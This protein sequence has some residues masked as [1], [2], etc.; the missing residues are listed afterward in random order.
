QQA[1][2]I[3]KNKS[4]PVLFQE[5]YLEQTP[6]DKQREVLL[7]SQK[8]KVIVCGRRSGKTQM[9]AGELIRGAITR[10]YKR[11][12]VIAP[13]YKQTLIVYNKILE[14]MHKGKRGNDILRV[15]Q[16][17]YP[18]IEL[19]GGGID[20]GSAD[21]PDSLRGEA[22][23]RVF[24]DES[25]FIKEGAMDAIKPLTFDTGAPIWETTTPW[26][27]GSV[28]ERWRRGL[29]GDSDYG[30]FHYNYK[31]NI[32]LADEGVKEIEKDIKEWGEDSIYVQCEIYGN[33]I[34]DRDVYF[35][36]ELVDTCIDEYSMGTAQPKSEFYLGVD[37]ARMGEDETVM[38]VIEKDMQQRIK[39]NFIE[40]LKGKKLT[41]SVGV[42]KV[43]NEQ[44]NFEKIYLD[45]TGL[46]AGPTDM[47]V[48]AF[49][50]VVEGVT[51]T[52]KS[53]MD[54]YSNLKKMMQQGR[55]K[56]PNHKK[57]IYQLLDLRY[58]TQ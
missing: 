6:H 3:L 11:Q 29:K 25:A 48:E 49:G 34:E 55:I 31:D 17:P 33:F 12:I 35:K 18:V 1:E 21:N 32:Y 40:N 41:E 26:G 54:M 39:V 7:S 56:F 28:W 4:N 43:L 38:I 2:W 13:R 10:E 57:L 16:N 15:V 37:F 14:L 9:I 22:Y 5:E 19:I 50:N 8:N 20:F 46:G 45:E 23:D 42:I 36:Q 58:E 24:I 47:L 27:K 44:Y 30:C 53:K 51:F 52:T